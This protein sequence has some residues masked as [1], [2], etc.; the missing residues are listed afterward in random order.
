MLTVYTGLCAPV[1]KFKGQTDVAPGF[2][3]QLVVVADSSSAA[4]KKMANYFRTFA[5]PAVGDEGT[6]E[7]SGMEIFQF[8]AGH[9]DG[10]DDGRTV[11]LA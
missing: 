5:Y 8:A 3:K 10:D 1:V 9:R 4:L 6:P 7:F 11:V 2:A